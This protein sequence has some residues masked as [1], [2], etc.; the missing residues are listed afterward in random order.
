MRTGYVTV[1]NWLTGQNAFLMVSIAYCGVELRLNNTPTLGQTHAYQLTRMRVRSYTRVSAR[2]P[3]Q[4]YIPKY[5]L[6]YISNFLF[7]FENR[8]RI[9]LSFLEPTFTFGTIDYIMLIDMI[10]DNGI[11]DL[12]LEWFK[13]YLSIDIHLYRYKY[14][15]LNNWR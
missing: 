9:Q 10:C 11:F 12:A 7:E 1:M 6:I 5:E 3:T 2:K 15:Y 13:Y 14:Q 4:T 8:L